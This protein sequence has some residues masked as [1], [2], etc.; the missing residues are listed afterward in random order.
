MPA[1]RVLQRSVNIEDV[2]QLA[3]KRA[4]KAIFDYVDGGSDG[5]VT[6]RDNRRAW[7]EVLFRPH[8]AVHVSRPD[9]RT[10]VLDCDLAMPML[11]GPIGFSRLIHPEGERGVAEAAGAEG[12]GFCMSSFSGYSADRVAAVAKGPLWYQL[13]LAGGREATE[14]TIERAW[15][16]GYKVLAVTVDTNTPG[17][18][19]RDLR[20]GAPHLM[21]GNIGKMLPH[22]PS[23]LSRPRWLARF[24]ADR[25]AMFFPNIQ[26]PDE[27]GTI[28]PMPATDVRR[29]LAGAVVTWG[30]L[31]WIRRV[32]PGPIVAKGVIT[33]DDA[34][35]AIDNG[36]AGVVVSNHGG[37]QLDT[38]YPSLRALPEVVR[39]VRTDGVVMVDGGIRRGGDMIKA[40]CMGAHAVLIGRA[41]AY[42]LMAEGREGVAKAIAILKADLERTMILLGV[43]SLAELDD[44]FVDVP[45][46]WRGHRPAV[47][48]SGGKGHDPSRSGSI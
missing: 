46:L 21:S 44:S 13:Y 19:E 27:Q 41:Y 2:R 25:D 28:R 26:V 3:R 43:A 32:W 16:A 7:D 47:R 9:L 34:R 45:E 17:M 37:R 20:N 8:N 1:S 10:R 39:A 33:D 35:R 31:E 24:L 29:M 23:I 12:I 40:L 42:G 6:L 4:P 15:K 14:A 18:R 36:C 48:A 22:L 5:E 11:L 30:D 38:C